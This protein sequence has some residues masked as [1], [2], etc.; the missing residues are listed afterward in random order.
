[1]KLKEEFPRG[2]NLI[3]SGHI[4][5]DVVGINPFI[6]RLESMGVEVIRVSGL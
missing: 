1:M 4:A 2:K 5:S 3:I 6:E